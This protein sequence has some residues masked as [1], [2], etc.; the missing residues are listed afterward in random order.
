MSA[1]T[2]SDQLAVPCHVPSRPARIPACPRTLARCLPDP[3][4]P[5]PGNTGTHTPNICS[6]LRARCRVPSRPARIPACPRTLARCL[7]DPATPTPGNTGTHTPNICS[8]LGARWGPVSRA[9]TPRA[10]SCLPADLGAMSARPR[11]RHPDL[12]KFGCTHRDLLKRPSGRS[13]GEP[14]EGLAVCSG[15]VLPSRDRV[16]TAARAGVQGRHA[17]GSRA[18]M[19]PSRSL[20]LTDSAQTRAD[21]SRHRLGTSPVTAGTS[22][23]SLPST[24]PARR[25]LVRGNNYRLSRLTERERDVPQGFHKSIFYGKGRITIPENASISNHHHG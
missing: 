13:G 19:T 5:T 4:T 3:A 15:R 14:E 9:I 11:P 25:G 6:E 8:E 2:R 10:D 18:E 21:R 1:R 12:P 7:S 20:I 24:A 16:V 23:V 22:P 17:E